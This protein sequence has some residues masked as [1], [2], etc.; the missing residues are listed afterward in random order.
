MVVV[1]AGGVVGRVRMLQCGRPDVGCA[2]DVMARCDR[3]MAHDPAA[4]ENDEVDEIFCRVLV[5]T[6]RRHA[7]P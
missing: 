6:R 3:H 4:V 7:G 1:R 2:F 5:G